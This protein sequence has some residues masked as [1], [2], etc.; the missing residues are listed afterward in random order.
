MRRGR[1]KALRR[2]GGLSAQRPQ[3]HETV[4]ERGL[5]R[6]KRCGAASIAQQPTLGGEK[7]SAG[8][9]LPGMVGAPDEWARFNMPEAEG[10]PFLTQLPEFLRSID[11]QH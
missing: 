9:L 7:A 11:A 6:F 1:G 10:Q 5:T 4:G 8:L 2:A 3:I